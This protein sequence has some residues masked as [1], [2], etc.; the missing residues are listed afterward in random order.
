MIP[1]NKPCVAGDPHEITCFASP[2]TVIIS[3]TLGLEPRVGTNKIIYHVDIIGNIESTPHLETEGFEVGYYSLRKSAVTISTVS[4]D[5]AGYVFCCAL[6]IIA[7]LKYFCGSKLNVYGKRQAHQSSLKS[8][9]RGSGFRNGRGFVG[10][11]N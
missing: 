1:D 4:L 9:G 6:D 11:I 10:P 2:E 3:W 8:G 5:H 7:N